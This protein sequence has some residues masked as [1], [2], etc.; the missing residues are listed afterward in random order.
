MPG[1]PIKLVKGQ[2][3][4]AGYLPRALPNLSIPTSLLSQLNG[5][6][7]HLLSHK[8]GPDLDDRLLA[9]IRSCLR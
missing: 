7:L 5:L 6:S 1:G 4:M 9:S 8:D 2:L 3:D